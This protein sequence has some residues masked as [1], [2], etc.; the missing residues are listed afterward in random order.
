[1]DVQNMRHSCRGRKVS[2]PGS[3]PSQVTQPLSGEAVEGF[4]LN[5]EPELITFIV[6]TIFKSS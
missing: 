1:M 5:G 4:S 6:L 2:V 3:I